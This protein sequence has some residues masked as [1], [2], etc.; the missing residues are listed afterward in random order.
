[1]SERSERIMSQ[2]AFA[3]AGAERQRGAG[4]SERSERIV[5]Q[6]ASRMPEPSASEAQA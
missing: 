6:R 1:M 3:H 5:W 4:M 2:R